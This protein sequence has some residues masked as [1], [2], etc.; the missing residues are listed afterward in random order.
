MF[1]QLIV[2]DSCTC[3]QDF[4]LLT[5]FANVF[6]QHCR[7]RILNPSSIPEGQFVD[8]KKAT[9]KLIASLEL[10]TSQYRF[11]HTKVCKVLLFKVVRFEIHSVKTLLSKIVLVRF[12]ARGLNINIL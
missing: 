4:V 2:L 10:D 12:L 9:E 8:S 6:Y 11:G 7:Y 5:L 3:E 1:T